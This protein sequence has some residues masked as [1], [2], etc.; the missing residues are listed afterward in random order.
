MS[1]VANISVIAPFIVIFIVFLHSALAQTFTV[2]TTTDAITGGTTS[3]SLRDGIFAANAG[4]A[5]SI[6]FANTV[7][8]TI[9]LSPSLGALP[10]LNLNAV[11]SITIDGG[12]AGGAITISGNNQFRVFFVDEGSVTIK[13]LTIA[14]GLGRGGAGGASGGGGGLGAGG[15]L[16]VN[17]AAVVTLSNVNFLANSAIGGNGSPGGPFN[18][19]GGGGLGGG[20]GG[21]QAGGGGGGGFDGG[22]GGGG[23]SGAFSA[24]GSPGTAAGA[25]GGGGSTSTIARA[26]GGGG[27]GLGGGSGGN[28][29]GAAAGGAGGPGTGIGG[30]GGSPA[31]GGGGGGNQGGAGGSFGSSQSANGQRFGG[32]G[33]SAV[34]QSG[35]NGG[36][37]GGGGGSATI[38]HSGGNGGW[39]GGGGN[40]SAGGAGGFGGGGGGGLANLVGLGGASIGG[41]GGAGGAG[42]GGSGG[43][44]G[45]AGL[46]GAIFVRQGGTLT[47][48]GFD[49]DATNGVIGGLGGQGQILSSSQAGGDGQAQGAALYLDAGVTAL[50]GATTGTSIISSSLGGV[51]GITK[52]G[53]GTLIL[54][55]VNSYT[56]LTTVS[57]GTLEVGDINTPTASVA[58]ALTVGSGG[59]LAGHGTVGGSVTNS[60]GGI[61][62]PGGI[63]GTLTVSGNY[64]QGSTSTLQIEVSPSA[65]SQLRVSGTASLAG[66]LALVYDPGVYTAKTYDILHAVSVS[67]TITT[68]SG[69]VPTGFQQSILYTATG[70]DL[71]LASIM[72]APTNDTAFTA[73]GTAALLGG[74]Q[75]NTTVLSYL[76]D[77]HG[78]NATTAV[79]TALAS[80]APTQL[81]QG[82]TPGGMAQD[83]TGLLSVLPD[84]MAQMGGWFRATGSF[85]SLNGSVPGFTT[86]SGGFLAG[87]DR[88]VGEAVTLGIAAGYSHTNLS[89]SDGESGTLDTPRLMLY[90]S[91]TSGP[92]AFDGVVG[93]AYDTIGAARP[94]A[95]VGETATST[96]DG[97]EVS[98]AAQA[99]YRIDL[100]G[101]TILPAAGL[102]YVHLFEAGFS[103]SGAPAFDL[104]VSNRNSD[105]LRPFIGANATKSFLTANGVRLVPEA[106]LTYSHEV[107]NAAPPSLVQVGGGS[108][109]V[110]GLVPARDQLSV[111]GGLTATLSE[112][113]G[114]FAAYHASLP[115]GNLF[116]QTVEAGLR[117]RF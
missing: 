90:A 29:Q 106:D 7:S 114:L 19:G 13:N 56:G 31:G 26:G 34:G 35:A 66:T 9:T 28:G 5:T 67:G 16:F 50:L 77:L 14:N 100:A 49:I 40:G 10:I 37:F 99:S 54:N 48:S 69:T 96:H 107:M 62:A 52:I 112:R 20:G 103:E 113:L 43:G 25:G 59:T 73:L 42:I 94:I 74:Q 61:V 1:S 72:I 17:Q 36:D 21:G 115:L 11:H 91:Y 22:G 117:Y 55:G 27:G 116:G 89:T 64:T 44:G 98:G 92:W 57:A 86:Q 8:G 32:G 45:G 71:A 81:G 109:S 85:A 93:Y 87:I 58:G 23:N 4:E 41:L 15:G 101:M 39:G 97:H 18:G 78:G 3:G 105:S 2:D 84:A 30:A 83:F 38:T 68:L 88:P 33:G 102:Q 79:H 60:V 95:S 6:V 70:V 76:S 108:F 104:A 51:G 111:G 110:S 24:A 75:A 65:A 46:G 53:A 63:I 82:G 80:T 47:I 12:G